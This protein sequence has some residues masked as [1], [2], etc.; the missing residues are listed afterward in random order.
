M[1]TQLSSTNPQAPAVNTQRVGRQLVGGLFSH[2][3]LTSRISKI[4]TPPLY[5]VTQYLSP[6]H[7]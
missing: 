4:A 3:I 2:M 6:P 1:Y 5:V 7:D